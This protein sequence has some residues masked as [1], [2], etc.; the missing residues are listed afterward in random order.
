MNQPGLSI[1]IISLASRR[2]LLLGLLDI[3]ATQKRAD[4]AEILVAID[5]GGSS[6]ADKRN[7]LVAAAKGDYICHIDDDD[8]VAPHYVSAILRAA[9]TRPDCILVRG[10]RTVDRYDNHG[11]KVT[12]DRVVFDYRLGGVEAEKVGGVLWRSPGHLCPVRADIAKSVS[13]PTME[14]GVGEDLRWLEA[15]KPKLATA[16]RAGGG[17]VLYYYRFEPVKSTPALEREKLYRSGAVLRPT[18]E[19]VG[20]VVEPDPE[21]EPA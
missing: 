14:G 18:L 2:K 4:E 13:F 15:I 11:R 16:Q 6:I 20:A 3:L 17:E 19:A 5:H 1:V 12:V 7:R 21:P 8:R 9:E 10:E